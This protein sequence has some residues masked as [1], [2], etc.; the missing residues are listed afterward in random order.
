MLRYREGTTIK[1]ARL[2]SAHA[3]TGRAC[4]EITYR[5]FYILGDYIRTRVI[6]VFTKSHACDYIKTKSN[7]W[8]IN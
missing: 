6:K 7:R 1:G 4:F 2:L 3:D 5:F 8:H